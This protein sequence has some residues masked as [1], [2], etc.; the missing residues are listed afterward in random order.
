MQFQ[1]FICHLYKIDHIN[2]RLIVEVTTYC[3]NS[4]MSIVLQEQLPR[5]TI[6]IHLISSLRKLSAS[7]VLCPESQA[8]KVLKVFKVPSNLKSPETLKT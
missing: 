2:H 7:P 3:G 6:S 8:F 4:F 1:T 5:I